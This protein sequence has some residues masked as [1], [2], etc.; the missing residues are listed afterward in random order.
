MNHV[1]RLV[2]AL[3]ALSLTT[4]Y[5]SAQCEKA[6]LTAF[7]GNFQENYGRSTS[8]E[9]PFAVVGASN[10]PIGVSSGAVYIYARSGTAWSLDQKI[11][12]SDNDP[13][14][15]FGHSVDQS[16]DRVVVGAPRDDG[17]GSGAGAAYVF[18]RDPGGWIEEAKVVPTISIPGAELG[19]S[20]SIDGDRIAVGAPSYQALQGGVW[21]FT[22]SGTT[23][24][25]EAAL[26]PTFPQSRLFGQS[27]A[28]DGNRLAIGAPGTHGMY[29]DSG[30]VQIF[31][32]NGSAWVQQQVI[33]TPN[34]A[35]AGYFGFAT[36]LSGDRVAVGAFWENS[37]VGGTGLAYVYREVAGTW[38]LEQTFAP[39]DL[40][41][42]DQFG[43]SVAING[44]N[45]IVGALFA[46][47]PASDSGAAY[48]FNYNGSAWVRI[49]KFWGSTTASGDQF[50]VSS[51]V[52]GN[53]AIIGAD[54][55][56]GLQG[57][58]YIFGRCP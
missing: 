26:A 42:N 15:L 22:R 34:P 23:W 40:Q 13:V 52:V 12:A 5:A 31:Q 50:G 45:L 6:A 29:H 14:D 56:N 43:R 35:P 32:F 18:R 9:D 38:T 8:I 47:G 2:L 21:T 17:N 51:D 46:D 53:Y 16:D 1:P 27:V 11:E 4:T 20:C 37:P 55:Y 36:A 54:F 58:A 33:V 7:D 30:T 10:H 3:A 48:L 25:Q 24:T 49:S 57:A 28:L 41:N 44:V 39:A 19:M